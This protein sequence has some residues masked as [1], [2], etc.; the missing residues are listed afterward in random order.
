MELSIN[1]NTIQKA[2]A[3]LEREGFIYTVKGRGNF[4]SGK[5][6][7]VPAKS[8]GGVFA[9]SHQGGENAEEDLQNP[10]GQ[11]CAIYLFQGT[12]PA[13]G[14]ALLQILAHG[15]HH[16][17]AVEGAAVLK[18][19]IKAAVIQINGAHRGNAVVAHK[20]FCMNKAG[21]V[22]VNPDARLQKL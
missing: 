12:F 7:P 17:P 10:L 22:F 21:G 1:P 15:A 11:G 8:R 19:Q 13:H 14:H 6:N 20:A 9:L 5:E 3:Q 18:V 2:Y 4:V 16:L